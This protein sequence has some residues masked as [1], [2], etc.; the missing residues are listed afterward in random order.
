MELGVRL[1]ELLRQSGEELE[2]WIVTYPPRSLNNLLKTG[3]D[4][5]EIL[6]V[7]LARVLQVECRKTLLRNSSKKQK[8]L[9]S[10]ERL[11]NA[12]EAFSVIPGSVSEGEKFI[13]VDDVIT[14]GATMSA[15]ADLLY[16]NGAAIVVPT[17]AARTVGRE[18]VR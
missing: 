7:E 8:E 2:G 13:L 4:H 1:R 3:F 16:Q 17:A 18:F 11:D 6:A 15:A 5:G 10:K 9:D 14:T 12:A